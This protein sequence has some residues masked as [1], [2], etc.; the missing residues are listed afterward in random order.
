MVAANGQ[1]G[2]S[3]KDCQDNATENY[4]VAEILQFKK[5]LLAKKRDV[6]TQS[7]DTLG[8]NKFTID[9]NELKDEFDVASVSIEQDLVLR[10]LDRSRK[11]L[12]E[13]DHA[14]KKIDRGEYG[15]CEG[16]GEKIPKKRLEL[17][18]GVR[19]GVEHKS[20]IE[21]HKQ[22]IKRANRL[23]EERRALLN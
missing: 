13:I 21:K 3:A 5:L 16:T 10:L 2:V 12:K 8:S 17:T 20:A 23:A 18:P 22:I 6:L 15:F 14:L 1:I 11:L 9:A 7:R 4:T 19:Y